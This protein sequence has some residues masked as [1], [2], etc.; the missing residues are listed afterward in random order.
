[1]GR[2]VPHAAK[3]PNP[4]TVH[5]NAT[6]DPSIKAPLIGVNVL[7]CLKNATETLADRATML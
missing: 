7:I 6:F 1:M 2:A 5:Y 4:A 3:D